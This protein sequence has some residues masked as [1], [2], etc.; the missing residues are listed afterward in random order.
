MITSLLCHDEI[1]VCRIC[2]R[3]LMVQAGGV[4]VAPM[5]PVI[6]ID[7][8]VRFYETVGFDVERYDEQFAVAHLN[9]Q[10]VFGLDLHAGMNRNDNHAG[11]YVI[12]ANAD[13]WHSRL[14]AAGLA[15]TSI[16]DKPWGTHEFTLTD[17]SGNKIRIGKSVPAD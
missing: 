17:P 15:V 8:S 10:T 11:C 16:E 6:D 13:E 7:D 9:D 2:I 4:D 3:W 1:K 5:L 14:H 12:T